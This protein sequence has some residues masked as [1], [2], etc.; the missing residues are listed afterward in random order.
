MFMVFGEFLTFL[1]IAV[2]V[3]AIIHY[4]F[5]YYSVSGAGSFLSKVVIAYVGAWVSEPVIGAWW[6][7]LSYGDVYIIPAIIGAAGLT[8]LAVDVAQTFGKR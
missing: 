5:G 6:D 3:A 1:I 8:I 4:G 2:I 7:V